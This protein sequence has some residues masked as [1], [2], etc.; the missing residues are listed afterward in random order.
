MLKS[1]LSAQNRI[2]HQLIGTKNDLWQKYTK[3]KFFCQKFAY[4]LSGIKITLI[5][6]DIASGSGNYIFEAKNK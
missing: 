3:M 5:C 2:S 6:F 4:S 1:F